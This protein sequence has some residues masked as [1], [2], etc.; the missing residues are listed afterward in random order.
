MP[1]NLP[2]TIIRSGS[3]V[4]NRRV[5]RAVQA[6]FGCEYVRIKLGR[7]EHKA[8]MLAEKLTKKLDQLWN[9]PVVRPMNPEKLLNAVTPRIITLN[10]AVEIYLHNKSKGK[11]QSF[12]KDT[13]VAER[14]MVSV[15]GNKDI[16]E[17]DRDDARA[18]LGA[19]R[20][21]GVKTSHHQKKGEHPEGN[22][23][24]HLH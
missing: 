9:S 4:F 19:L 17:Y 11:G 24:T 5:P 14:V 21:T 6:D 2:H 13:R 12:E 22:L 23:R 10:R 3:F 15:A 18:V 16:K 1:H 20:D 8:G 7:D